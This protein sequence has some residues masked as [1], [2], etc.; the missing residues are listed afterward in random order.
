M[1]E[2]GRLV[3]Y[4]IAQG[5][6]GQVGQVRPDSADGRRRRADLKAGAPVRLRETIVRDF[7]P[8]FVAS[9][10]LG[11]RVPRASHRLRDRAGHA[12]Q[13]HGEERR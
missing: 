5:Q 6:V 8:D 9:R 3:K 11:V 1:L 2:H 13:I 4:I 7:L 12:E 10:T